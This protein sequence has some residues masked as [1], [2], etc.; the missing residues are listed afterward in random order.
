MSEESTPGSAR[1]SGW[2]TYENGILLI[3]GFTFGLIFFDRNTINYLAADIQV[4]LSLSAAQLGWLAS[5][6]ALAWALS[7]YFVGAWSDRIGARKPF[8]L[9]SIVVF[10]LCSAGSGFATG[11]GLLLLARVVMGIAEGP[12]L[13]I[14]LSIMNEESS[15][16]RRGLNA[17][18]L[19]NV[20]A[21]L[22][23][24]MLSGFLVPTLAAQFG[25]RATFFLTGLPGLVCALLVW[26]YLKEP[27]RE[28]KS[29]AVAPPIGLSALTMLKEHNIRICAVI[30]IFMVAWFLVALTFLPIYFQ[31]FRGFTPEQAGGV[32]GVTGVATLFSGFLVP[33]LSD[34]VGRKPVLIVFCFLGV[35]TSL[36][37]LYF[38]GPLW[39][40]SVLMFIGWTG[41]GSFPLFMGVVPGET[42]AR[43]L[44]ATS[45][46][47]VVCI[48]E[49]IGGAAVPP[50]AGWLADQS[51][52]AA[53]IV[54]VGVCAFCAG[55]AA[56][57]LTETAPSRVARVQSMTRPTETEYRE[58]A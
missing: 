34:R 15:P 36:G 47:L 54:V 17:G 53:P 26:L 58:A 1:Q 42:V 37:A 23:G 49:L 30:S 40:L 46:G 55:V 48:G 14:C 57:F 27:K 51:S 43:S 18:I 2:L 56:L 33:A 21:A 50:L 52:L 24:T 11:F 13:P 4:E 32:V 39:M 45:M 35:V 25:W 19:Q 16:H 22:I 7:A 31:N 3:L 28:V 38:E 29:D 44:A 5:G 20:F 12:F 41:T 8:V 9:L 6:L 10:S